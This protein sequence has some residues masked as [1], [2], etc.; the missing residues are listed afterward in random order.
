MPMLD[1]L[2]MTMLLR[3]LRRRGGA[4]CGKRTGKG[5]RSR[6]RERKGPA[7]WVSPRNDGNNRSSSALF[8]FFQLISPSL[9]R[10][11][12]CRRP[13]RRAWRCVFGKWGAVLNGTRDRKV[14]AQLLLEGKKTVNGISSSSIKT[15]SRSLSG[16][17]KEQQLASSFSS[18]SLSSHARHSKRAQAPARRLC[19]VLQRLEKRAK[20]RRRESKEADFLPSTPFFRRRLLAAKFLPLVSLFPPLFLPLQLSPHA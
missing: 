11:S 10:C 7:G 14:D 19:P 5:E 20:K 13:L 3:R 2:L 15:F 4:C 1:R 17:I 6:L 12:S 18:S 16:P 8:P 9:T